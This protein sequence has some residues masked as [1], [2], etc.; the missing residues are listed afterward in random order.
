[1]GISKIR[2]W[3]A[4]AADLSAFLPAIQPW[5]AGIVATA[6]VSWLLSYLTNVPLAILLFIA[7]LGVLTISLW[8]TIGV[9]AINYRRLFTTH[10]QQQRE[11]RSWID[12]PQRAVDKELQ[13]RW[14]LLS[15]VIT[16]SD[17]RNQISS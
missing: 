11:L 5:V 8:V 4:L 10:D 16:D 6:A 9:L 15:A 7:A 12:Q 17:H 2:Q 1:M 13:A 14:S 3:V